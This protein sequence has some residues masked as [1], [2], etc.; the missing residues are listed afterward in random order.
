M[1]CRRLLEI[2]SKRGEEALCRSSPFMP[3]AFDDG[4]VK[5]TARSPR[6]YNRQAEED[7]EDPRPEQIDHSGRGF[8][9]FQA[10]S[11]H[12]SSI[13]VYF[14]PHHKSQSL[15]FFREMPFHYDEVWLKP[16]QYAVFNYIA[17]RIF[18][19]HDD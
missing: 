14:K 10:F 8:I 9:Y 3:Y 18:R 2:G 4:V 5:G 12:R 17:A 16:V 13:S 1:T 15:K 6:R 19:F 11:L 7:P